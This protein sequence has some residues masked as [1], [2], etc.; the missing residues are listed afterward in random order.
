M[1]QTQKLEELNNNEISLTISDF[2]EELV[3]QGELKAS[4]SIVA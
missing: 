2:E 3:R 1:H 4:L